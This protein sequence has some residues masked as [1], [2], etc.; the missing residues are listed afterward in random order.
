MA[1][2]LPVTDIDK[3]T[4]HTHHTYPQGPTAIEKFGNNLYA[5]WTTCQELPEEL[6]DYIQDRF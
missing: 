1:L 6:I 2:L 4:I 5:G 3:T